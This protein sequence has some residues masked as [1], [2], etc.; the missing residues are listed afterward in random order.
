MQPQNFQSKQNPDRRILVFGDSQTY[1]GWD[2][3]GGWCDRL[4]R[5]YHARTVQAN[6]RVKTQVLNLGIGG[7]TTRGLLARMEIEIEARLSANW[8]LSIVIAIGINDSRSIKSPANVL[9]PVEEYRKNLDDLLQRAK[10]HTK[11]VLMVGLTP[12]RDDTLQYSDLI[13]YDSRIKQYDE[14]MS[15]A[16]SA[17]AIEKVQ[18]FDILYPFRHEI[19]S[20]DGLHLNDKG[21]AAI[22]GHIRPAVDR[23]ISENS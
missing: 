6:G 8:P 9:V 18:L 5:Y 13:Y 17:H 23:L 3:E 11:N 22:F 16:A 14:V 21:H 20:W 7:E 12:V 10:N 4:K 19:F 15:N 1:G 2:S